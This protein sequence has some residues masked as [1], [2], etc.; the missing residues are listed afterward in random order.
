MVGNGATVWNPPSDPPPQ[1]Y[2]TWYPG[3]VRPTPPE[4]RN[5]MAG[6]SGITAGIR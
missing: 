3:G 4:L 1:K 2:E 5:M 6:T